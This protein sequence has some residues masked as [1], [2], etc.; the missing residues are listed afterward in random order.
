VERKRAAR[1]GEAEDLQQ[2]RPDH[3]LLVEDRLVP[4]AT[5]VV[6]LEPRGE[7][8]GDD[9]AEQPVEE[10]LPGVERGGLLRR[11]EAFLHPV[12]H[13]DLH[14]REERD[15]GELVEIDGRK[16]CGAVAHG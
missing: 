10:D 8:A 3:Q 6:E 15:R 13:Q 11:A 9:Q 12:Q 14:P 2:D 7:C 5:D 4:P 16:F 1:G